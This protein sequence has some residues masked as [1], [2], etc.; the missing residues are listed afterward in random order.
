MRTG[1]PYK[2]IGGIKFYARKEIKDII[3]YLKLINNKND[4]IALKRIINEPKRGIGDTALD[5]LDN[6]AQEKGMS[7]FELIQDNMNLAGLRSAGNII[8]FRDM[9]NDLMANKETFKVSDLIKR[10]LKVSG[11][12]DMLNAE[13]TKETEIRFEN[14]M[15]FIGVAIEFENE[16]AENT[17]ED[18]LDSIALVS[19][20]DN[21]DE[22][23]KY[24]RRLL[25]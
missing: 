14:L 10:V 4:N 24:I 2:L 19:D 18:F 11:Y 12:E 6:M 22:S 13:G 17:L 20:V 5:K 3:S 8:L 23:T 9:M 15:E 25:R 16:N 21:L 1:T 7:I